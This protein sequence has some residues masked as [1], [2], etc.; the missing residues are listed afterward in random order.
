MKNEFKILATGNF[1]FP[2]KDRGKKFAV[3]STFDINLDKKYTK[4]IDEC[5]KYK[6]KLYFGMLA[7]PIWKALKKG[8]KEK[9]KNCWFVPISLAK[10]GKDYIC[11]IDILKKVN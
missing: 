3:E 5:L 9:Y 2:I 1:Y 11:T 7:E 10:L 8:F 6:N 4:M